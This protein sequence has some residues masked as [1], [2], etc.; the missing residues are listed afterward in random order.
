MLI[1]LFNCESLFF[2]YNQFPYF[3]SSF[4]LFIVRNLQMLKFIQS[5]EHIGVDMFNS[6]FVQIKMS[7]V[8][9]STEHTI[10][11]AG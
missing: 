5:V 6:V 3:E 9:E 8:R 2:V 4:S 1:S 11:E 10:F 7:K